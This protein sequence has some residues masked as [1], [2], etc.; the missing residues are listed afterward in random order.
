MMSHAAP[1][2]DRRYKGSTADERRVRRR[3][4]FIRAAIEVYGERGYRQATVKSVCDAAGLTERYF[5]ESFPNSEA[6]LVASFTAVTNHLFD[7]VACAGRMAQGHDG[8]EKIRAMLTAYYEGLKRAPAS[9][10]VFL[11]EISGVSPMVDV[12]MKHALRA[13]GAMLEE[14]FASNA[15]SHT[16]LDPLVMT[17]L[18]GGI[19]HIALHWIADGYAR[20]VSDVVNAVLRLFRVLDVP[21]TGAAFAG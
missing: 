14:A 2:A 6:L 12:E 16:P 18:V 11:V 8:F 20:P 21:G 4:Q 10:R 7:E 17:G 19:I 15:G 3:E 5:Y 9:A 13:M 1:A